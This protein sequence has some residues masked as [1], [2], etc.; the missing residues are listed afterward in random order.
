MLKDEKEL[1][2]THQSFIVCFLELYGGGAA[3][4]CWL[5]TGRGC[6]DSSSEGPLCIQF[7]VRGKRPDRAPNAA[8]LGK[9]SEDQ[10]SGAQPYRVARV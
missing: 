1:S 9:G 5:H 8:F 6:R 3:P 7:F 2:Q 4:E 10:L